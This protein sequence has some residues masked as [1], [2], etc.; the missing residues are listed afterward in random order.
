LRYDEWF[1]IHQQKHRQILTKL[2][3][4]SI[5]TIIDYFDYD[6]MRLHESDFC[7]LY[8]EDQKCHEMEEL[9]CYLCGC[10]NFRF[11]DKGMEIEAQRTLYS[12]CSI[13]SKDGQQFCSSDGV[14]HDCSYCTLPHQKEYIK[15]HFNRAWK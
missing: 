14:H 6:N 13:H 8:K 5:D 2:E 3:G 15:K 1:T 10:P 4:K 11:D 12:K 9:N 7:P